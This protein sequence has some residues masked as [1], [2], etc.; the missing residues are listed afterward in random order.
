[1]NI[2]DEVEQRQRKINFL[3]AKIALTQRGQPFNL[4]RAHRPDPDAKPAS[5]PYTH[6]PR[7]DHISAG[8]VAF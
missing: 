6:K 5:V 4:F 1:M 7:R 3:L 8:L 2:Q